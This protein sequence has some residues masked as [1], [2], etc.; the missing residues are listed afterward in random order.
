MNFHHHYSSLQYHMI[1]QK[2]LLI[3]CLRKISNFSINNYQLL[4]LEHFCWNCGKICSG[5]FDE[6]SKKKIAFICNKTFC[7]LINVFSV[8]YDQFN[9]HI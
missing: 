9:V 4:L 8:T 1:I 5:F 7:T 3:C 6:Q 2:S